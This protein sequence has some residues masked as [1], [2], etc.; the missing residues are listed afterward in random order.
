MS[1]FQELCSTFGQARARTIS[2]RKECAEFL[3]GLVTGLVDYL[4][5]P[6]NL[7]QRCS[8]RELDMEVDDALNGAERD[9][10][11]AWHWVLDLALSTQKNLFPE[12]RFLIDI[13][14]EI[15]RE[16]FVVKAL[17]SAEEFEMKTATDQQAE[18]FKEHVFVMIKKW[19]EQDPDFSLDK[20]PRRI[21]FS[22]EK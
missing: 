13:S 16:T 9:R 18:A 2:R 17:P 11:G 6:T 14:V 8:I 4:E 21:G 22:S 7:I 19:L 3:P 20:T 15:R 10:E 1:K 12:F 5:W